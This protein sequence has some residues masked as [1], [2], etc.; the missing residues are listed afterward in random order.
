ML[1]YLNII[2]GD[3]AKGSKLISPRTDETFTIG[4]EG[5]TAWGDVN[6]HTLG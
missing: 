2:G 4:Y 5:C 6:T 3:K 1:N